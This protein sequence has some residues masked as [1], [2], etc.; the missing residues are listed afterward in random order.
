MTVTDFLHS[1][2]ARTDELAILRAPM[3][4]EDLIEKILDI[5]GDDYK[6]LVRAVKAR[7]TSISFDELH[8]K[9]LSFEASLSA[10]TKS[11]IHLPI[12]ANPTNKTTPI[13]T[14]WR[15]HKNNPNWRPNHLSSTGNTSLLPPTTNPGYP[16]M[17][18]NSVFPYTSINTTLP[19]PTST[20]ISTWIPPVLTVSIPTSLQLAAN[21]LSAASSQGLSLPDATSQLA[22][23]SPQ[24]T[25]PAR[26]PSP[27]PSH[28]TTKLDIPVPPPSQ[29]SMTTR[30]KNNITKPIQKL[31]LH[32]HKPTS[33]NVAPTSISQALKDHNWR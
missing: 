17:A 31:N 22:E 20:T 11:D 21:T 26:Q 7:D 19:H 18:T 24:Q 15:P 30:A 3:E 8:E 23:P 29:Y 4:E 10:T 5:L 1:V 6:E 9:L 14:N 32:T 27:P 13:N 12:T 2:K 25:P 33:Q 16:P 28:P